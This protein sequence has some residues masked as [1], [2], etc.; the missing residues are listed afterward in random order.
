[1]IGK[2]VNLCEILNSI[3]N[4]IG[5]FL[6]SDCSLLLATICIISDN[7]QKL[8]DITTSPGVYPEYSRFFRIQRIIKVPPLYV[9]REFKYFSLQNEQ[10]LTNQ[11]MF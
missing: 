3:R 4:T 11:T 9:N 7:Q 10:I 6:P 1:M 2:E 5:T 8:L